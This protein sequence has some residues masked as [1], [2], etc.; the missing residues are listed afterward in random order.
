MASGAMHN[1]AVKAGAFQRLSVFIRWLVEPLAAVD[2]KQRRHLRLLSA[3]LLLMAV[4]SFIGALVMGDDEG[5]IRTVMLACAPLIAL[6]YGLSRTR[7]YSVATLIAITIP[8]VPIVA[9]LVF[10]PERDKIAVQFPWL[11]LPLLICSLL[12][13]LRRTI[14]VAVFY[15][16]F[17]TTLTFSVGLP[18]PNAAESLAYILMIIFFVVAVT[19]ARRS[20]H[21]EIEHQLHERE[22]AEQA[23]RESEEKFSSAFKTNPNAICI[24]SVADGTFIE[25]NE[26]FCRFTAYSHEEII[27]RSPFDL[28]L[29]VNQEELDRMATALQENG[30]VDNREFQSR[31]KSGEVRLGLFYAEVINIGSKPCVILVITDITERRRAEQLQK[32]ENHILMLLS[33]GADLNDLLEAI[34][35]MGELRD[36]SIKGSV[37]VVD[38]LKKMLVQAAGPSLSE[39]FKQLL[40]NGL[41]I[42][43]GI[44]SCGTAAFRKR[45]VIIPDIGNSPNFEGDVV[46]VTRRDNMLS[47]W[48]QP[49]I[50]SAG[51][52]LGTIANY[53]SRVGE[54]DAQSLDI[55]EWSARIAA[56][57]IERKHAEE[58]LRESEEKFAKAFHASPDIIIISR[59]RDH[60]FIEVNDSFTRLT[61][62]S[63]DQILNDASIE[64]RLMGSLPD[65]DRIVKFLKERGSVRNQEISFHTRKGEERTMLFSSEP[66]NFGGE[67]C[68]ITIAKD[69]TELKRAEEELKQAMSRLEKSSAQLTATNRELETFSYSVSHDLR[70]PLRSI[71]GFSQALLEDYLD[72]FDEQGR[73]YL[74]RLRLASQKMGALIDGLLKLSRLTRNEMRQETVDLGALAQEIAQGLQETQP[75]HQVAFSAGDG[76]TA[77]GDPQLLRVML[78]NLIGNAWKFSGHN[79]HPRIE[80][81]NVRQNGITEFFVRDNGVGFDMAYAGKLFGAFQR[82]HNAEDFPGTGIGLATVQRIINRH[83][84]TIRAEGEVGKGA[85]F[86]F[87][88]N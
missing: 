87:T 14:I 81:G 50:S 43:E 52:L 25:V 74:N 23:L 24:V 6:G 2:E 80:F 7:Y 48:S 46:T 12:L 42:A 1:T 41:P 10:S 88:L 65:R 35:R 30:R 34:L 47:C 33:Q 75:E 70:S 5:I 8:A 83:G 16:V 32:D 82:L 67:P 77:R 28:N 61:G 37:L 62:F 68:K 60:R 78:E 45:R 54:P 73:D 21:R 4:N 49:I 20:D 59:T 79:P 71:D 58:A 31:R 53:G 27:G 64:Y 22:L 13:S 85:T 44:G 76:L 39:E 38:P 84:G 18:V 17:I 51:E 19:A 9:M 26:S 11:A 15:V 63:R 57:A 69:I 55:L 56:I 36:P 66:I 29:F 86:Y 3:F 72:R 40:A